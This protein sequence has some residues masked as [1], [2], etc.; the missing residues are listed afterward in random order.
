MNLMYEII[1]FVSTLTELLIANLIL[2]TLF[3][4]QRKY[5]SLCADVTIA[6]IGSILVLLC[7][8]VSLF[9]YFTIIITGLFLSISARI[10]YKIN[11]ITIFSVVSFYLLCMNCFDFLLL[12][13]IASLYQG[14]QT[15]EEIIS[16]V[17]PTR[18]IVISTV[19]VL[20]VIVYACIRKYLQKISINLKGTYLILV[21][22][23]IGFLGFAFLSDQALKVF[24]STTPIL[25]FVV[26]CIL[27]FII[28]ISYFIIMRR[29]EKLRIEFLEM[30]NGLLSENYN[31]LNEV[32]TNNAKLYHDLNNHLNVLYQLIDEE[33]MTDAK[34]YIREISKPILSLSKTVW[35]GVDVVDVVINSKLKKMNE[36]GIIA[37]I[38]VE[39]PSISNILPNDLC[40]ILSNLLDNAIE[41]VEKIENNKHITLTIRRVNFFLFIRIKNP[42]ATTKKFDSLLSTT[43]QNKFLHGWGAQKR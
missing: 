31:S 9:S 14:S 20:W 11:Y 10:I 42:C 35:T 18:A 27:A 34:A 26:I 3:K 43:K 23:C 4:S 1:E 19:N 6:F 2:E 33:K 29:E 24:N 16:V 17:G 41:A 25:W 15:L 12:T 5:E 30:R 40:A 28:F 8:Q 38:N 37:D 21:T 36:L 7:N 22:S 32:Y 13:L 39:F